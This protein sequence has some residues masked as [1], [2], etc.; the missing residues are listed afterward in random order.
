MFEH[1]QAPVA[2]LHPKAHF[3][4]QV[5]AANDSTSS[6]SVSE[7]E[8]DSSVSEMDEED[9][10]FFGP[11][12][13]VELKQLHKARDIHRRSTEMI[14]MT[15]LEERDED[16]ETPQLSHTAADN[17]QLESPSSAKTSTHSL[18]SLPEKQSP[19]QCVTPEPSP[20]PLC[21]VPDKTHLHSQHARRAAVT[22]QSLMRRSLAK[23]EYNRKRNDLQFLAM[24][25]SLSVERRRR[26]AQRTTSPQRKEVSPPTAPLPLPPHSAP[27]RA[28]QSGSNKELPT[29]P[30]PMMPASM[31]EKPLAS[32]LKRG[33][34]IRNWFH[35][36]P[37]NPPAP[38]RLATATTTATATATAT[39]IPRLPQRTATQAP[40]SFEPKVN[41]TSN[42][43]NA[44]P[45][46]GSKARAYISRVVSY[47]RQ[48]KQS[49]QEKPTAAKLGEIMPS[50]HNA[51]SCRRQYSQIH[52]SHSYRQ[53][54][55]AESPHQRF[56]SRR[57]YTHALSHIPQNDISIT[58]LAPITN[59]NETSIALTS[60]SSPSSELC[61]SHIL[62]VPLE[63][64]KPEIKPQ[65]ELQAGLLQK[66]KIPR[67]GGMHMRTD[68]DAS[69]STGRSALAK[70]SRA[71][72]AKLNMLKSSLGS[73][74]TR[75]SSTLRLTPSATSSTT[76][77]SEPAQGRPAISP[78]IFG[79]LRT[80]PAKP[81]QDMFFASNNDAGGYVQAAASSF[82]DL[83]A[84]TQLHPPSALVQRNASKMAPRI[85]RLV[86]APNVSNPNTNGA[87]QG[88]PTSI[89]QASA[90]S[91]QRSPND[92]DTD[93]DIGIAATVIRLA[94]HANGQEPDC[95]E[96][97]GAMSVP[98]DDTAVLEHR[99]ESEHSVENTS[100]DV[101]M[102]DTTG[103]NH[104]ENGASDSDE[105]MA[106][107]QSNEDDARSAV[108]D[109]AFGM[110][111]NAA[112]VL[113][114]L[115]IRSMANLSPRLSL[116]LSSDA[117]SFGVGLS[118]FASLISGDII[119]EDEDAVKEA[120]DSNKDGNSDDASFLSAEQA[121]SADTGT[122][123]AD[124]V[125]E[126]QAAE[127]EHT[128]ENSAPVDQ[129]SHVE[130]D[131]D[132]PA[133]ARLRSLRSRRLQENKA[134]APEA[135]DAAES[136]ESTNRRFRATQT[137]TR[138]KPTDS[139]PNGRDK[140]AK[141]PLSKMGPLQL[142]RLT[143]LNTRRNS[144]YMTCQI[145]LFAMQK[146]GERPPSPSLVMQ[147]RAQER[148]AMQFGVDEEGD[149]VYHSIYSSSENESEDDEAEVADGQKE[150]L[151]DD[152]RPITPVSDEGAEYL[153][154]VSEAG[155]QDGEEEL[156]EAADRPSSKKQR[157]RPCVHWGSRSVLR[158]AW[159]LGHE[160]KQMQPG[161]SILVPTAMSE[162][163]EPAL[164]PSRGSA[165]KR[166]SQMSSLK[167][168][169]VACIKY[170]EG[171]VS[172]DE[173]IGNMQSDDDYSEKKPRSTGA[174][175]KKKKNSKKQ[176]IDDDVFIPRRSTRNA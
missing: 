144:T 126:Q 98:V 55:D 160:P 77:L 118:V 23:K 25:G 170:P 84:A 136:Q 79:D 172:D 112:S 81:R 146:E 135:D 149:A 35:R 108:K 128:E 91:A 104:V 38:A 41:T 21:S 129:N 90:N 95:S 121:L 161:K 71:V 173:A 59:T 60:E 72:G 46:G 94:N 42:T 9:E 58:H 152:T 137:A 15:P 10:V 17:T 7:Y 151:V 93:E 74:L 36:Q 64:A 125:D 123:K 113:S 27:S 76:L 105:A 147:E 174:K 122:P 26:V 37:G 83:T 65:Q 109:S 166:A 45:S 115:G 24:K 28:P 124:A 20:M 18:E 22:V 131:M 141:K 133:H 99:A 54:K 110:D 169:R 168:I 138:S 44:K 130:E 155:Q 157:S 62:L 1:L 89:S 32:P 163:T 11:M 139:G 175:K 148:R 63:H 66:T 67:V 143:K 51:M 120:A 2:D 6:L 47:L 70:E 31:R 101:S 87:K 73:L 159:L 34:S 150:S 127:S 154:E 111:P 69:D 114:N 140:N 48:Q 82:G 75:S 30:P 29:V 14:T 171:A 86:S 116:R 13:R 16:D 165:S 117:S 8:H 145:E 53:H 162:D 142:D 12:S 68:S 96:I 4:K 33:L 107:A 61:A 52:R 103:A 176:P 100:S 106:P 80:A 56:R 50:T 134:R 39:N 3:A 132:N 164:P 78:G 40:P 43:H 158:S 85:A 19:M 167:T 57:H 102:A 153:V 97:G 156:E 119:E 49:R 92:T 5:R 88:P